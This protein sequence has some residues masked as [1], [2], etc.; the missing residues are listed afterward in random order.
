M[1]WGNTG[2]GEPHFTIEIHV[3][4]RAKARSYEFNGVVHLM[5]GAKVED[6]P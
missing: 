6:L 5:C 4:F 2:V 1:A 3:K